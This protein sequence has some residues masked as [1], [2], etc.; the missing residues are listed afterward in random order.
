MRKMQKLTKPMNTAYS[1]FSYQN[2][3]FAKIPQMVKWQETIRDPRFQA[4]KIRCG[5]ILKYYTHR[6]NTYIANRHT[7]ALYALKLTTYSKIVH[8]TCWTKSVCFRLPAPHVQ[9]C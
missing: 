9:C 7:D 6:T 3:T 2:K 8:F 5:N 4:Y 1:K